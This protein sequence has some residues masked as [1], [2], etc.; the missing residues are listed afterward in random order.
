MQAAR[1]SFHGFQPAAI[2][3]LA[4]LAEHNERPWF[5]AHKRDYEALIREPFDVLVLTLAER[6]RSRGLPLLADPRRSIFRIY[7]DTRFSRDKSPYKT[8]QSARFGWRDADGHSADGHDADGREGA[9][10]EHAHA[11]G[12]YFHFEP[13]GMYLGGGMYM[14]DRPM[15]EAWRQLVVRDP[16]SVHDAIEDAGFRRV[17]DGVSSHDPYKRVP[18]GYPADH[19]DAGL[20]RMRD[21]VF[22]RPLSD[23]E[24]LSP[25]LPDTIADDLAAAMPVFRLLAMLR[26]VEG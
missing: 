18:T 23:E 12:G 2:Q 1:S 22:G 10:A 8:H 14:P 24:V 11:G 16:G 25:A 6:F 13:G 4:D 21:V 3:F 9:F 19:P 20:L 7:R 26:P 17:F 5:Q 15:L